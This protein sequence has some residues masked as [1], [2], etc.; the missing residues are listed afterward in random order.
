VDFINYKGRP[1][2]RGALR[3]IN[4]LFAF[5]HHGKPV[6]YYLQCRLAVAGVEIPDKYLSYVKKDT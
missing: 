4:A 1:L 6:P 5:V 2:P 3:D